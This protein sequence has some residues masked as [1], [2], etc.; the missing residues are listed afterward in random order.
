[1]VKNTENQ[2]LA[3]VRDITNEK[4]EQ[5]YILKLS[6]KHHLTDLFNRRYFDDA[7][8]RMDYAEYLPLSIIMIDVNGLKLTNDAFGHFAGDE[9]LNKVANILNATS[10]ISGFVETNLLWYV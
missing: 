1:M 8:V 5:D 9:L 10:V 6:Y 2:V 7:V 3:I 4:R